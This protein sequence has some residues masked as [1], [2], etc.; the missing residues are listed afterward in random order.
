MR[1]DNNV[2]SRRKC[3]KDRLVKKLVETSQTLAGPDGSYQ[4][5]IAFTR[6]T[7]VYPA[8]WTYLDETLTRLAETWDY[9]AILTRLKENNQ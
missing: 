2:N 6:D 5:F 7:G 4:V 8:M 9:V 1:G 3:L